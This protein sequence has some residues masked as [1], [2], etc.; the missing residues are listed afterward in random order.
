MGLR[1]IACW[2]CGFESHRGLGCLSLVNIVCC[3]AA[4][5]ASGWSLIQRIRTDCG[6]WVWSWSLDNEEA[7]A[8]Y[9]LLRHGKKCFIFCG[10]TK[11]NILKRNWKPNLFYFLCRKCRNHKRKL[12]FLLNLRSE[13]KVWIFCQNYQKICDLS[14]M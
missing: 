6:V 12:W 13:G 2:D 3:Q 10:V 9:G 5:S 1:S 7:L 8:H 14:L 4:F 11:C